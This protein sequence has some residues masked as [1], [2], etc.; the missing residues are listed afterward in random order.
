MTGTLDAIPA[1]WLMQQPLEEPRW[2]VEGLLPVGLH[3]LAGAPKVGKSWL[4]LDLAVH[5]SLGEPVWEMATTPCE[6]LYLCLEDTRA[7]VQRRLW[8]LADELG[9]EVWVAV[10]ACSMAEGLVGQIGDFIDE[11]PR[12]GLVI[13]DTLQRV[14]PPRADS[15]YAADYGDL[16]EL[17][18]LADG[19][20]LAVVAV[21]H[22]RK[23]GDAD[24]LNRVSGTTGITG[25]ADTTMVLERSSRGSSM[26]ALTVTGR[27]V[28]HQEL[29]LRFRDCR[30]ELVERVSSEEIE[31]REVPGCVLAVLELALSRGRW[32][33]STTLLAE[34]ARG[35]DVSPD[36]LGKRLAQ[37]SAFLAERGVAYRR[38]RTRAGSVV[39]LESGPGGTC[40]TC[41]TSP[42][43]AQIPATRAT[44]ATE[45]N[46]SPLGQQTLPGM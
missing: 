33:G 6:V 26:A 34:E 2:V 25:S 27:D 41:G 42:D 38:D 40:G 9:E 32:S 3:V 18:A 36:A 22:T 35:V 46:R 4:A 37:H 8:T 17:K 45:A 14:R 10:S 12:V 44:R 16:S 31:E 28:E 30:W 43:A 21:H 5:A 1:S 13:I 29:R 23:M 11:H 15:S 7:R 39:T 19:R 24:V 20:G